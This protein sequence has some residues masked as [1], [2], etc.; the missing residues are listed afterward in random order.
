MPRPATS[1]ALASDLARLIGRL[2]RSLNHQV[3]AATGSSAL[4]EAQLEVLRLLRRHPGIRV[5]DVAAELRVAP[6]TAST[7]VRLLSAAEL[8]DRRPDAGDGRVARLRLSARAEQRLQLWHDRRREVLADRLSALGAPE[9]EAVARAL[10][11]LEGIA[12]SLEQPPPT[13]ADRLGRRRVPA[14]ATGAVSPP[15]EAPGA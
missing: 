12:G 3:R 4:P 1:D 7:L 11:V 14:M 5:H 10:P 13:G 9:R 6:N 2:R 8:V 15:E